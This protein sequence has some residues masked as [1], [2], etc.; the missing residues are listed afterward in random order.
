M[1]RF[2]GNIIALSPLIFLSSFID[3]KPKVLIIRD[4]ISIGYTPFVK[5]YF[6]GKV[7]VTDGYLELSKLI[8][9][10]LENSLDFTASQFQEVADSTQIQNLIQKSFDVLFSS[11]DTTRI[12]EFYT[13]DFILLEN[14]EVWNVAVVKNYLSSAGAK[15]TSIRTNKFEFIKTEIT[16]N[17]AWIAYHNYAVIKSE[18]KP[19]LEL[20]WLESA[21]AIKTAQ[22]WRLK[23]LHS[24]RTKD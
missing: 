22:G 1:N 24:T 11:Y 5:E 14:G 21:T 2:K 18:G 3:S 23:M 10:S 12:A 9:S 4:S 17:S 6:E 16:G 20:H 7:T 15:S 13:S 19:D 8:N